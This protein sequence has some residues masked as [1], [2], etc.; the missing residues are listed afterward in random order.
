MRITLLFL[1]T[2]LWGYT[3]LFSQQ[4]TYLDT[5]QKLDEV[6]IDTKISINRKHSGKMVTVISE[7]TLQQNQG[8]S[9]AQVLN[10]VAGFE[11]NGSNSNNGQNLGYFVRG[12]KN[13]QVAIVI[14]GVPVNDASHI[15]NEFDLRLLSVANI[16][17]IEILKGA[18]SVLYGSGAA[19][20]VI[21]ITT[22]KASKKPISVT[23]TSIFGTDK[24]AEDSKYVMESIA[25][26]VSLSGTVGKFFYQAD[27]NHNYSDGLSAI[28]APKGTEPFEED[29]FN[30]FNAKL[31]LG[32]NI[33]KDITMSQFV[34]I[35][36]LSAGFDDF[37]Y[38]DANYTNT[39]EQFR[40]GGHFQWKFNKGVYVFNDNYSMV[41]REVSSSFPA[42]Y[43]SRT[44]NF[45]NYLQYNV[46]PEL[47]T[48]VGLGGNFSK[49]N[50]FTIPFGEINFAQDVNE[51]TAKF[52]YFDPYLNVLYTSSFGLNV[53]AGARMNMHS[54]YGNHF[55]YQVNPSYYIPI[56]NWGLKLLGSYST[57]YIT[58]SLYQI[59]DPIYG[60]EELQ[61]EE[62]TT[63]E[64]GFEITKGN[65]FR[66]SA[67]YFQRKEENFVD[68]VLVDPDFFLYQYQNTDTSFEISGVEVEI[69]TKPLK[70]LSIQANYTLT[71]AD[72]ALTL[73]IPEHK[74]NAS[75]TYNP[76]TKARL[77]ISFQYVGEREDSFFNPDTFES[78]TIA[79]NSYSLVHLNASYRVTQNLQLLVGVDNIFNTEFEELYRYQ[80]KGRNV[81]IGFGLQF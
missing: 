62:N 78:E 14:D 38:T 37:S 2:L 5:I 1:I 31:N 8:K 54:L 32:F 17:K 80:T 40:T 18:S 39:T 71:K 26:A 64:G 60:N 27:A 72:E 45:D 56:D 24:S 6:Y 42:K 11:I 73:R 36:K 70:K 30:N 68:F 77:G 69:A 21:S 25:N 53:N 41:K 51:D 65:N 63:L 22:K 52:N 44:Y 13:R 4:Q 34:V 12:G 79:L 33:T 43:D 55:V 9:V 81:R 28:A 15:S 7:E 19:T 67:V 49:M 16:E 75:V 50:S 61:P 76:N 74:A 57:A 35:D 58:P 10:E 46:V 20:A 23:T 47:K 3:S 66:L 29:T 48:I 59:Y